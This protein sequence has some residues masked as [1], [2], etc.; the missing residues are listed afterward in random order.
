[1]E[2]AGMLVSHTDGQKKVFQVSTEHPLYQDINNIVKKYLGLDKLVE[3]VVQ[4]LGG[5]EKVYLAGDLAEGK[6]SENIELLFLGD[7]RTEY[8]EKVVGKAEELV[9]KKICYSVFN[10]EEE[11]DNCLAQRKNV[12]L[13]QL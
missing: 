1:L 5:L 3:Q 8:L 9:N 11:I 2:E 6:F 4:G 12:L 10:R 13:W 7:L